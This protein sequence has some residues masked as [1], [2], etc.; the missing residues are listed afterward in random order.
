M[1]SP[2][3]R[4]EVEH[5][6]ATCEWAQRLSSGWLEVMAEICSDHISSDPSIADLE[7]MDH[8]EG[9]TSQHMKE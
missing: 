4:E 3:A 6:C 5:P 2:P 8:A 9:K 1:R 7:H